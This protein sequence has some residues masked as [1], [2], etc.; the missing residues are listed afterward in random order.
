M[1]VWPV[2][3]PRDG[4]DAPQ[5][6]SACFALSP[7]PPLACPHTT[8]TRRLLLPLYARDAAHRRTDGEYKLVV[9]ATGGPR[10]KFEEMKKALPATEPRYVVYDHEY[11]S[12]DGRPTDK[13]YLIV[14]TPATSRPHM[15]TF[16]SSQKLKVTSQFTGV[17][18]LHVSS[19]ADLE[20]GLGLRKD[21]SDSDDD[22]WDPDA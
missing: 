9:E 8:V 5:S 13:L 7:M 18:D 17:E 1:L 2:V 12:T 14:W 19:G 22:E 11:T 21:E 6:C 4:V 10:A 20:K 15:K 16:Y 3:T